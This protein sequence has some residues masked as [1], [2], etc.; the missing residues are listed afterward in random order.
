M[1]AFLP[2]ALQDL[3]ASGRPHAHTKPMCLRPPPAVGLKGTFQRG[4][5]LVGCLVM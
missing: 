4:S 2:P 1:A 5:S 3:T